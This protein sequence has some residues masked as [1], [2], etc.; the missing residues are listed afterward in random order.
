M[1]QRSK[2]SKTEESLTIVAY[3]CQCGRTLQQGCQVVPYMATLAKKIFSPEV[4]IVY[5]TTI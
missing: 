1:S 3:C 5:G 2:R 4:A